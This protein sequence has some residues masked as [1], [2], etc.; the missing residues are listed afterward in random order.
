VA[1]V[2]LFSGRTE[3][4]LWALT[5]VRDPATHLV[6]LLGLSSAAGGGGA[7]LRPRVAAAGLALGYA[8]SIRPTRS[9]T[10][11]RPAVAAARWSEERPGWRP[12]LGSSPPAPPG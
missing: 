10:S 3:L 2:V 6:A 12:A 8:G 7:A 11:R 9:S 4:F 5:P 1:L